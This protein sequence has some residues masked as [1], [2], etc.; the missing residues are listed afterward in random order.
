MASAT[1]HKKLESLSFIGLLLIV[2][3]Q[4]IVAK[5]IIEVRQGSDNVVAQ[6]S[7]AVFFAGD[8]HDRE[9][10]CRSCQRYAAV[11]S[12]FAL[13]EHFALRINN[14]NRNPGG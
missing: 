9:L 2:V 11:C 4:V 10:T 1:P 14:T 13:F 3:M 5:Q 12:Q 6:D 7:N 8:E